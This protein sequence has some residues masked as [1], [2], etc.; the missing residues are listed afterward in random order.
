MPV[1]KGVSGKAQASS[2]GL[3]G[4]FEMFGESLGLSVD[5]LAVGF[6]L[7]AVVHLERTNDCCIPKAVIAPG[8]SRMSALHLK[9][10]PVE[11]DHHQVTA[12]ACA[13]LVLSTLS[14]QP[15]C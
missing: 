5:F 6:R 3:V 13:D 2:W 4:A 12:L 7:V 10:L 9:K 11:S 14:R 8:L 1:L 15:N